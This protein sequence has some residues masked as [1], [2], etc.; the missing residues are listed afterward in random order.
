MAVWVAVWVAQ[1]ELQSRVLLEDQLVAVWV[2]QLA[3]VSAILLRP[4]FGV[5]LRAV[6]AGE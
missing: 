4:L 6:L 1:W 5:E 3:T 2:L